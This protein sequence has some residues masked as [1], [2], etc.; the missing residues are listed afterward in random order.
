MR[1]TVPVGAFVAVAVIAAVVAGFAPAAH[2]RTA[3]AQTT[4]KPHAV[5]TTITVTA[6][7]PS[8]LAFKLSK[9]SMVTPGSITFKVTNQG[10]AF[11]N[12]RI[13]SKPVASAAWSRTPARARRRRPCITA[14]RPR[15]R[16]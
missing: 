11:H 9:T 8:E 1:F 5:P 13:C 15:S 4:A 16:S 14:T 10:V 12:F 6:G 2:K 3:V 7:K